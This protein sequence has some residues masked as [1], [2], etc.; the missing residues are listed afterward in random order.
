MID[1]TFVDL[2]LIILIACIVSIFMYILRQPFIIGYLVTGVLVSVF[3]IASSDG[4]ME[5]FSR[6]GIVLL[7]F[8]VGLNLNP[9]TVKSFGVVSLVAGLGQIIITM[10]LGYGLVKLLG[11]DTIP[12]LYIAAALTFSSTII[13]MKLLSDKN[14]LETLHGRIA[15]GILIVQ[16]LVAIFALMFLSSFSGES[17]VQIA[18]ETI[19]R[20]IGLLL[21]LFI[22]GVY[23]LPKIDRYIAR[24]QELLFLFSVGW[25][26]AIA[27]VFTFFNFSVEIGA[28]MAGVALSMSPYKFEISS[29]VRPLRDFFIILFFILLGTQISFDSIIASIVPIIVTSLFV[30]IGNTFIVMA[31]IGLLGYTRRT[32]FLTGVTLAQ[33][34]EFSFILLAFGVTQGHIDKEILSFVTVVG[35][36]SMLGSTYLIFYSKKIFK[37]LSPYIKIFERKGT[38]RDELVHHYE[39]QYDIILIGY[40]RIGWSLLHSF[41]KQKKQFLVIDFNPETIIRLAHKGYECRYGDANDEDIMK[42][43]PNYKPKMVISTIPDLET[44]LILIT[45]MKEYSKKVGIIA[46]SHQI[47]EAMALYEAGATYVIMPHFL[48]GQYASAMIEKHGFDIDRFLKERVR[49]IEHL[50]TRKHAGQEHPTI[51]KH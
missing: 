29:K 49:H 7:L 24:T 19:L 40:N 15:V 45:R 48:G 30:L 20:G 31:I 38:L 12:A 36:I 32:S 37:L 46:V 34:S 9:K 16:D 42:E 3:G 43:L 13:V 33:I 28:L 8:I 1:A 27:T 41:K 10:F 14:D 50:K 4:M 47:E 39:K 26:M 35:I 23:V 6:I 25:V 51:T 18:F 44:N 22:L 17:I 21:F 11:F 2:S 5:A